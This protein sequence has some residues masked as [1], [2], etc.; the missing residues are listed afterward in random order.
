MIS[1]L[2]VQFS[3]SVDF[4][5]D[6]QKIQKIKLLVDNGFGDKILISQDIHTKHRM[7]CDV[8]LSN[9]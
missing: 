3:S 6:A 5:S 4:P 9:N 1:Y 7:V 8:L 2:T